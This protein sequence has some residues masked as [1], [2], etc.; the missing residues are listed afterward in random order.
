MKRGLMWCSLIAIMVGGLSGTAWAIP[1]GWTCT[2]GTCGTLGA[3]GVVTDPPGAATTYEYVTT[4]GGAFGL[5]T[6]GIGSETN[7]SRLLSGIFSAAAGDALEF[8]FNYVTSDGSDYVEYAWARLLD[9]TQTP[10]AVLFTA[11]TTPSG[12]TV[13]GFGLPPI[14]ATI[15]PPTP[16][17]IPGGPAWSPLGSWSG[18][19]YGPGCG[20]TGWVHSSYTIPSAGNYILEFGVV[21]WID[22]LYDS[23]LAISGTTI[24]GVPIGTPTDGDGGPAPI[25]EPATLVLFGT[26]LA[27]VRMLKKRT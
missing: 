3:N 19:C 27:A 21:N 12:S 6:L 2:D 18:A 4:T 22:T 20:Y 10:V 1:I 16:P 9:D 24:G 17:I 7:G 13:P 8:D 25:P 23:G 26:G 5:P 15:T 11:R 14:V